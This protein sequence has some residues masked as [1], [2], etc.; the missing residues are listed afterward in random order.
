MRLRKSL[1]QNLLVDKSVLEEIITALDLTPYDRILEIGPGI[2]C[3]TSRLAERAARVVAVEID[4]KLISLLRQ[5]LKSF[6][7]ID[8]IEADI[9][10]TNLDQLTQKSEDE[11][12]NPKPETRNFK[13]AANLP[14][15]IT[16]PVIM[17]LLKFKHNFTRLVIMVQK[18]VGE[19]IL[20]RPGTKAYG[21]LSIAVQYHAKPGLVTYVDRKSFF[22]SPEVDS[23]ILT[24]DILKQPRVALKDEALFFKVVKAGFSQRRKM[25]RGSLKS[26][27]LE[28]PEI[29]Q[30]LT[31]LGINPERRGETLSLE[32][33]AAISD[34]IG[35]QPK[36]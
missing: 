22:P 1:G 15:Y 10:K 9:L 26:L 14:Y 2:G 28:G 23:I 27:G 33:F 6:A 17:H 3:L 13:V 34:Q 4:P 35:G 29:I 16:S 36:C 12:R 5:E 8:L 21:V 19:R 18:E 7:N 25:L 32:E 20:S 11:T 30:L 24:L 31:N